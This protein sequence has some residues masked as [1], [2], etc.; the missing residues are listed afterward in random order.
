MPKAGGESMTADGTR[1][2]T[3]I[4]N[5]ALRVTVLH[6]G[7]HIAEILDKR[8]GIDPLW[9][10]PWPSIDPSSYAPARHPEYGEGADASLLAGIMGHSGTMLRAADRIPEAD[11]GGC[12]TRDDAYRS[13]GDAVIRSPFTATADASGAGIHDDT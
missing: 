6:E 5:D 4:E 2:A 12:L 13:A 9:V 7:G 1:R 3:S 8:S 10:P 11:W